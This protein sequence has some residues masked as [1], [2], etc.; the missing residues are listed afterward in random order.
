[1]HVLV[2]GG[3]RFIGP[4]V[5]RALADAGHDVTV[6]HRGESPCDARVRHIHGDRSHLPR[7]LRA[8][9]VIDMW[10]MTEEHARG[11]VDQFVRERLRSE[12]HTS[13]LQ[14]RVELVCRLLL[15][16]KKTLDKR[17]QAERRLG[18]IHEDT[19]SLKIEAR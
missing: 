17:Y 13:E 14:S 16:K 10:C 12:E 11:L 19:L 3:T 15:E 9:M 7:D 8:D 2:I 6:F 5:V 1:M 4:H 18:Y